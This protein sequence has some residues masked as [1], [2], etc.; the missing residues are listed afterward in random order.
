MG[1][2]TLPSGHYP[3]FAEYCVQAEYQFA[4]GAGERRVAV[5]ATDDLLTVLDLQVEPAPLDER[6][7]DGRRWLLLPPDCDHVTVRC[8]YRDYCAHRLGAALPPDGLFPDAQRL[9]WHPERMAP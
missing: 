8:R 5:P 1:C 7:Q 6:F 2:S 4:G 3:P 9:R